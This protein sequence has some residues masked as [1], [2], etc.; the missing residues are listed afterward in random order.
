M[1]AN[2]RFE[3][4]LKLS[5]GLDGGDHFKIPDELLPILYYTSDIKH[6]IDINRPA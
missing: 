6:I 3:E 1:A 4:L 2:T 5:E